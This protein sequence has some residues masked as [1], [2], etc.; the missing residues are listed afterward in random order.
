MRITDGLFSKAFNEVAKEY[1]DISFEEMYVDACA[2]N[3]IDN[4]KFLMLLLHQ[5]CLEISYLMNHHKWL[6]D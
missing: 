4:H 2:M 1:P 6:V 3:L 5:T